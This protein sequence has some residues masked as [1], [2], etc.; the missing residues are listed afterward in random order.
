M[1][2]ITRSDFDKAVRELFQEEG[3]AV[4]NEIR[5]EYGPSFAIIELLNRKLFGPR[6]KV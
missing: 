1:E 2:S 4:G 3:Y 5:D 6:Q